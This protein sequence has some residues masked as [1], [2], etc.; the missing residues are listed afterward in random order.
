MTAGIGPD[1]A[2]ARRFQ[3]THWALVA[4]AAAAAALV[5]RPSP[6][7]V[8]LGGGVTGVMTW[9]YAMTFTAFV[10][11]RRV[12]FAVGLLFV[13]VGGLLGLGWL[14]FAARPEYRPEPMGFALGVS[15]LPVAAVWE[16]LRVR[17]G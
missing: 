1:A 5:G 9:L 3:A 14:A 12:R 10:E 4:L 7:S 16:A 15:C 8:L 13:K 11:R 2:R 17:R 6:G